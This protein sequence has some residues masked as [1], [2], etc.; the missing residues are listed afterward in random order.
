MACSTC[1]PLGTGAHP[2]VRALLDR[3]RPQRLRA[4]Y[5]ALAEADALGLIGAAAGLRVRT[6]RITRSLP[7]GNDVVMY[8]DHD[9]RRAGSVRVHVEPGA[10]S[11]SWYVS[12]DAPEELKQRLR[13]LAPAWV[14]VEQHAGAGQALVLRPALA[15]HTRRERFNEVVAAATE[16]RLERLGA[17]LRG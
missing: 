10:A 12:I 8:F 14:T 13:S 11:S 9:G 5:Q 17:A 7:A 15:G 2:A 3:L 6:L 4:T 1:T 16:Q